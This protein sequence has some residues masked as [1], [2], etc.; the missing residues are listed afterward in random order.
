MDKIG[1]TERAITLIMVMALWLLAAMNSYIPG[2]GTAAGSEN[3]Y[4]GII[5]FHVIA[6]SNTE[7]DQ[8]LKLAVRD[9]VLPRLEAGIADEI[10]KRTA[11]GVAEDTEQIEITQRYIMQNMSSIGDWAREYLRRCGYDYAVSTEL[12]VRAIPEKSYGDIFFPAGNYEALTITIGEGKGE[13]WWCVVF[14]PL[15]LIDGSESRYEE[16]L[17]EAAESR[18]VLKSKLRELLNSP[19]ADEKNKYRKIST[20]SKK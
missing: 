5:R 20:K 15:C 6:N 16:R 13:N 7:Q 12:G 17:G 3:E 14:P 1:K 10:N 11:E 4:P 19:D 9:Y 18:I 8:E 2:S